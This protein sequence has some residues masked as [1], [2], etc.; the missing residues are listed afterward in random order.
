MSDCFSTSACFDSTVQISD[1][2]SSVVEGQV[3]LDVQQSFEE[4]LL[5]YDCSS[6]F[7]LRS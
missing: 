5:D 7:S 1:I 4:K 2:F 3:M 6:L